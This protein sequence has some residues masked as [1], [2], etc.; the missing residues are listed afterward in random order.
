MY[1]MCGNI[2]QSAE[3]VSKDVDSC[4]G[5]IDICK[6]CRR[7]AVST[8]SRRVPCPGDGVAVEDDDEQGYNVHDDEHGRG[9]PK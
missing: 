3:P 7:V 8:R 9:D 6:G 2:Q 1:Q 5:I 4:V